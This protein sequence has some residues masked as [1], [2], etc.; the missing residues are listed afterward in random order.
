MEFTNDTRGPQMRSAILCLL[1]C[2]HVRVCYSHTVWI[3]RPNLC[4]SMCLFEARVH[5]SSFSA[6][7]C[8]SFWFRTHSRARLILL[9]PALR[10]TTPSS[11]KLKWLLCN[12]NAPSLISLTVSCRN[13]LLME[14]GPQSSWPL[15]DEEGVQAGI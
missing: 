1:E 12:R 7:V 13:S 6:F 4:V 14:E 8:V 10:T 5:V 11:L 3:R 15:V 9:V 2:M